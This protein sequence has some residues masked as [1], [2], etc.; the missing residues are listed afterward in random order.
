MISTIIFNIII[1]LCMPGNNTESD[2][3]KPE[4]VFIRG[5]VFKMGCKD[6]SITG[7]DKDE[8]PVHEVMLDDFSIGKYE[9]T[10]A[11]YRDYC[12]DTK[13]FMPDPPFWRWQDNHPVVRVSYADAVK[14]CNWLTSKFGGTWRLPTEAE[15]EFAARGGL[16]S[17]NFEYSGGNDWDELAWNKENSGGQPMPVGSKKPNESGLYDMSGNVWEWCQDWYDDQYYQKS[18]KANPKGP[19]AGTERIIRG[20]SWYYMTFRG[21]VAERDS[22]IPEKGS[23]HIGFRVVH[24]P[25]KSK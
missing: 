18:P 12:E 10:V 11:Q 14:Y 9:V 15:W 7:C 21:R 4:V 2:F 25:S 6:V 5:G 19:S 17:E 3:L 13:T 22:R 8:L 1:S 16:S 23:L 24:I 20:G